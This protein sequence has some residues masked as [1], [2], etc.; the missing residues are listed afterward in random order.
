MRE[1]YDYL[2]T[3]TEETLDG[4]VKAAAYGLDKSAEAVYQIIRQEARDPFAQFRPFAK[5][6]AKGGVSLREYIQ[7]LELFEH[8][9]VTGGR[10][11]EAADAITDNFHGVSKFFGSFM[12]K[13][14]DGKLDIDETDDL[15]D[16]IPMLEKQLAAS[17]ESLIAHKA[18]LSEGT[19]KTGDKSWQT[20]QR[21]RL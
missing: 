13:L 3:E 11:R 9:Y 12:Q 8:K 21:L 4:N 14:A 19:Q 15:L 2:T 6:L 10:T 16:I 7:T 17:K 18:K 5:G 20:M 1:T